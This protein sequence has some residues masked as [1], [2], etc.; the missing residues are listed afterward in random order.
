M[1][2][3]KHIMNKDYFNMLINM[4]SATGG[5]SLVSIYIPGNS[6]L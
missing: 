6:Q 1:F 2:K 3:K 4:K 5:T